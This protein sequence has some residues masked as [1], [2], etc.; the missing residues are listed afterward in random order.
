MT[1]HCLLVGL[2][3]GFAAETACGAVPIIGDQVTLDILVQARMRWQHSLY[4]GLT[5]ERLDFFRPDAYIGLTGR[6]SSIFSVRAYADVTDL[7][8]TMLRDLFLE[9]SWPAGWNLRVGQFVPPLSSEAQADPSELR[10]I[11]YSFLSRY[12]KPWNQRDV[13][14]QAGYRKDW[15]DLSA[16]L[17]NGYGIGQSYEDNNK[18]KD[19]CAR[20]AV[21]PQVVPGGQAVVRGYHGRISQGVDF[22]S[23]AIELSYTRPRLLAMAECQYTKQGEVTRTSFQL[24]SAYRLLT[25]VQPVLRLQTEF[26]SEDRYDF[27]AAAGI[28]VFAFD[29]RVQVAVQ[30]HLR[31]RESRRRELRVT[32]GRVLLQLQGA[33]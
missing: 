30:Y 27:G 12:W 26:Q 29:D 13:G 3:V 1:R 24:V 17:L 22:T 33:L 6:V 4:L 9:C 8:E 2:V 21:R 32:E 31:R 7:S 14:V 25:E 18:W 5:D 11:G 28:T 15:L 10:L 20:V 19:I 16:A 23:G